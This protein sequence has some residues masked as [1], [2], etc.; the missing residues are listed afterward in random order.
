MNAT[1]NDA[2][3][4]NGFATLNFVRESRFDLGTFPDKYIIDILTISCLYLNKAI[5]PKELDLLL[6]T[7]FAHHENIIP[8]FLSVDENLVILNYRA[9][10]IPHVY[11]RIHCEIFYSIDI[12]GLSRRLWVSKQLRWQFTCNYVLFQLALLQN[13][14]NLDGVFF[15]LQYLKLD[16]GD[17]SD[18][19]LVV[20]DEK[21]TEQHKANYHSLRGKIVKRQSISKIIMLFFIFFNFLDKLRDMRHVC[22]LQ[23][24]INIT[25]FWN[26]V[27]TLELR[28]RKINHNKNLTQP[29]NILIVLNF[30]HSSFWGA[31]GNIKKL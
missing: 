20:L 27:Y 19:K 9:F 11:G 15:H 29:Y 6:W 3:C 13:P 28:H 21:I 12:C 5:T 4:S 17:N 8:S 26:V 18:E 2:C 16:C 31:G 14:I 30:F 22:W 10:C 7:V 25:I 23:R 24:G 1:K